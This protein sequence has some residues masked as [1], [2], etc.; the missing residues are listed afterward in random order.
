MEL[1]M[2]THAFI[3]I[4]TAVFL[5]VAIL[6]SRKTLLDTSFKLACTI[7]ALTGFA[8]IYREQIFSFT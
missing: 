6:W 8:V 3:V 7:L 2:I 5:L 4:S 1:T